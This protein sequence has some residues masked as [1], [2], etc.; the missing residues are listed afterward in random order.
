MKFYN[1]Q[2][3]GFCDEIFEKSGL[4]SQESEALI[5][6]IESL[7]PGDLHQRQKAAEAPLMQMGFTFTVYGTER[8]SPFDILPRVIEPDDWATIE[9]GFEQRIEALNL[10]VHDIYHDQTIVKDGVPR[11][12]LESADSFRP[13]CIGLNPPRDIWGHITGTNSAEHKLGRLP[14]EMDYGQIDEIITADLHDYLD[15][16]QE[17]LTGAGAGVFETF[18]AFKPCASTEGEI[19]RS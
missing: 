8:I 14:S 15:Q 6:R 7:P 16:F 12:L 19:G 11:E 4:P 5:R 1:Y 2:T 10:L 18:F 3:D 9:R 13:P 17:K